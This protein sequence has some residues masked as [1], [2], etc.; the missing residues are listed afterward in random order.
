MNSS[1]APQRR[2]RGVRLSVLDRSSVRGDQDPAAAL[3]DTVDFARSIEDLG[4]HRFWVA[5]HH[6]VPGVAG[7]A[8]T[9]LAAAVAA[10]TSRIRVGTGGVMLPNH[11]PLVVAEQFGVLDALYPGRI[12][13]GL[14]RSLAF[15]AGIRRALERD[16]RAADDFPDQLAR[17]LGFIGGDQT[18]DPGVHAIPGEGGAVAP[19]LLATGEGSVIAAEAG[20]PLVIAPIAGFDRMTELIERYRER[21]RPSRWA[22]RPYTVVSA[23]VAAA[24]TAAEAY[25]LLVPEA[26][27][28]AYARTH[29]EFPPLR[30]AEEILARDMTERERARFDEALSGHV[31][32][33]GD[34]VADELGSLVDRTGA[35]EVLVTLSTYDR[36]AMLDSY[37]RL[38]RL[39]GAAPAAGGGAGRAGRTAAQAS[40]R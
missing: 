6:S 13:M 29:A 18:D 2:L 35:D 3:R 33:T 27:S 1:L 14:G 4:Y 38:A 22:E 5:E 7:S 40:G 31:H 39:T 19:F 34:Q 12:D 36:A 37:A 28:Y 20:L 15:T 16:K 11:Q 21:F 25:R 9:V 10:A 23:T 8:P 17:L 24:A 26:W 30:P 32:G